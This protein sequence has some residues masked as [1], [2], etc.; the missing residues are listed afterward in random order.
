MMTK[1]QTKNLKTEGPKEKNN[2]LVENLKNQL[3]RA[4]ADYDNLKKRSEDERSTMYKLA[5][6]SFMT[7]LLPIID[8]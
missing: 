4:L 8:N 1:K 5:S 6:I 3:A 2:D 7:K